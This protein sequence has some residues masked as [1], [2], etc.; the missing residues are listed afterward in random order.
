MS[1]PLIT[2]YLEPGS[3]SRSNLDFDNTNMLKVVRRYQAIL[4][5]RGLRKWEAIVF[6]QW[7]AGHLGN[8]EA[9]R[10]LPYAWKR[11]HR[12]PLSP[13]GWW[14]LAKAATLSCSRG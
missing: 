1:E 4:G 6:R 10:A 9:R 13:E 14:I 3:L 12:Q 7:A 5:S 11:L 8:R 2:Y